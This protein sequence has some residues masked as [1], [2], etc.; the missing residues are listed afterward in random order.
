[1]NIR[2]IDSN[3]KTDCVE[4]RKP[5]NPRSVDNNE[6]GICVIAVLELP[7]NLDSSIING[8]ACV[9]LLK[10]LKARD[11]ESA[12]FEIMELLERN[13]TRFL[14]GEMPKFPSKDVLE[15]KPVK[16]LVIP[17]AN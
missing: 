1:M 8:V 11:I 7:K 13:E 3:G 12:M 14:D 10:P 6:E 15:R 17:E 16:A 5:L 9:E 4:E 2:V